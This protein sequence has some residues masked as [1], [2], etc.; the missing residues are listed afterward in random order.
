[1]FC[2]DQNPEFFIE[3]LFVETYINKS[4]IIEKHTEKVQ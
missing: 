4:N 1:M 3:N 2:S